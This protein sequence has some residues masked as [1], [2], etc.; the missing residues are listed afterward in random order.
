L[1]GSVTLDLIGTPP[2]ISGFHLGNDFIK[3][4]AACN[5]VS[6]E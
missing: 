1:I 5:K 4:F 6:S 3:F 2:F